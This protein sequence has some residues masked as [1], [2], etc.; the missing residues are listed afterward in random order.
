MRTRFVTVVLAVAA[1]AIACKDEPTG[2]DAHKLLA[3]LAPAE[4]NDTTV[5][6]KPD[7]STWTPA[8]GAFHGIVFHP[9]AGPDTIGSAIRVA[10]VA[11]VVY[12]ETGWDSDNNTPLLGDPVASFTSNANG[13]FQSPTIAGGTYIVTFTPPADSPY[14]GVWVTGLIYDTSDSG[15]W[16]IALPTK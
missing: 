16:W 11:I 13:E 2:L 8:P 14:K 3:G 9:G 4:S 1:I 10:N 12:P 5:T 7:T 6:E 15:Q